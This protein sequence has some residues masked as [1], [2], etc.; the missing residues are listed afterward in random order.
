MESGWVC[1][2]FGLEIFWLFGFEGFVVSFWRNGR[3]GKYV[4]F[5]ESCL[6]AFQISR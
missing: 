4:M 2:L 3:R 1:G 5:L 6:A